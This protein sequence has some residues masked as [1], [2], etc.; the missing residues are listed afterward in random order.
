MY[1]DASERYPRFAW[2]SLAIN[3]ILEQLETDTAGGK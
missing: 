1:Y 2:D 3:E